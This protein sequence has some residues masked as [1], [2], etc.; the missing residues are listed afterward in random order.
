MSGLS[1]IFTL[2]SEYK[3]S[4]RNLKEEKEEIK[5]EPDPD[6]TEVGYEDL[7]S[8]WHHA[9]KTKDWDSV[10]FMLQNY[11]F[12]KYKPQKKEKPK[13][14]LRVMK[15][16][17]W[18]RDKVKP[19]EEEPP[20]VIPLLALNEA[21][22]TPLH[23]AI[24]G[25]APD[26]LITRL[27]FSERRAALIADEKGH[28][29]FHLS[30][31][32][33]RNTQV[34]DRCIR[35]NFHNMQQEDNAGNTALW[36]AVE[37]AIERTRENTGNEDLYWGI[38]RNQSDSEWQ[39]RQ[40]VNWSRV[41]FIL[42]SYQTRRKVLTQTER[43]TLLQALE[44]AA[45]PGVVE[46][47][48][49]ACQGMLHTDPT[50]AASALRIFM[51]RFY[52]IK[53][54]Q[55]LLH[56]FPRKNEESLYAAR[57]ILTDHYHLGC[58]TM[59]DRELS[60][61]EEMERNALDKKFKRSLF[62]LEWWKK[63]KCMLRFCGHENEKRNKEQF[64]DKHLLQAALSNCDIPPSLVQLLMVINP[65]SIKFQHPFNN[66]LLIHLICKNWRYNLFPHSKAVGVDLE[67]DEPP[68]EQ[69]LKIIVASDA[70]LLRKRYEDRLPIHHAVAT[71]KSLEF[72]DAL[73]Q[74]DQQTLMIRDAKTKLYPF[75]LAALPDVNRNTAL[76]AAKKV[77]DK[78]WKKMGPEMRSEV[79]E[80]V[81]EEQELEQLS[82][83]FEL[84]RRFPSAL[85]PSNVVQKV[86]MNKKIGR[87]MVSTHFLHLLYERLPRK[88]TDEEKKAD[89]SQTEEWKV[90]QDNLK[91]F[92][93]AVEKEEI[94]EEL[95]A[96]WSKMKF[97]IRFCYTGEEELP[98]SDQYLLHA[99][100]GNPDS[101]PLLIE[102]IVA[103][104]PTSPLL[105]VNGGRVY[106]I[107]IAAVT[108][109][110]VPHDFE[111]LEDKNIFD[112]LVIA[113][114]DAA[115]IRSPSGLPIDIAQKQGK[116]QEEIEALLRLSSKGSNHDND[117]DTSVSKTATNTWFDSM[118]TGT[119]S[120]DQLKS[121]DVIHTGKTVRILEDVS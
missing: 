4:K 101:P 33:E 120:S 2:Y 10:L 92:K 107:H 91:F 53:N 29:P 103:L 108:P 96:W 68:M 64:E 35:A 113:Y 66:S 115:K 87:G 73:I 59:P 50:L 56:H 102:L 44:H 57:R 5:L 18:V 26:R 28:L 81:L 27:C 118:E 99:A 55:L 106:P 100:L 69:V 1:D 114:P 76:W 42:L 49:M 97:W 52:P 110:Y 12:D 82:T 14:R 47:C 58:R 17:N 38:P 109:T 24:Q 37:R 11:D 25:L 20:L 7:D 95:N 75:Q 65:K 51:R 74:K 15:A 3:E 116:R 45:P 6:E 36:Y 61:R 16:A 79:V 40:E 71:G 46:L 67:M 119:H 90:L 9:I 104:Y 41:K 83:I 86:A 117:D 98:S 121:K 63:I 13:R 93:M 112:L 62:T 94:P 105:P 84:L 54:L 30:T 31:I 39:E 43:R 111:K 72:L 78:Q 88:E 22:Q 8:E 70:T 21:G 32:H 77:G 19:P 34:I 89:E 60:Y 80:E 48:I 23:A 85:E